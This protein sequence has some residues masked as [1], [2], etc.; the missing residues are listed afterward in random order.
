[1]EIASIKRCSSL[2]S[3]VSGSSECYSF[4]SSSDSFNVNQKEFH[5]MKNDLRDRFDFDE[6][7]KSSSRDEISTKVD[8]Y[9]K[10]TSKSSDDKSS[11]SI[12]KFLRNVSSQ[13][14]ENRTQRRNIFRTPTEYCFVKGMS[15]LPIRVRA[16]SVTACCH[17]SVA[18][19]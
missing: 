16:S 7:N 6:D 15:G 17:R 4:V 5:R 18:K 1:M 8:F 19:H 11:S 14:S 3:G 10:N 2:A 9:E 12:I 13:K